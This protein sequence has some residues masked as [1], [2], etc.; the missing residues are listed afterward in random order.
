MNL[1]KIYEY[2]SRDDVQQ[3]MLKSAE[4]REVVGVFRN[5]GFGTRPNTIRYPKDIV[6]MARSGVV[7][8]HYSIERWSNPMALKTDNYSKMRSGWD[9]LLDLDCKDFEHGKIGALVFVQVLKKHGIIPSIKFSG[10]K[11]FHLG[12]PWEAIPDKIDYKPTVEMYPDLPR[13]IVS[14]LKDFT[15]DIL[16]DAILKS[17]SIE[18]LVEKTG[19]SK[20]E[21]LD[22][23]E[24]KPYEIVDVDPVMISPRHLVRMPYSLHKTSGFFSLPLSVH[25]LPGF[26]RETADPAKIKVKENFLIH[27]KE[28]EAQ[29]LVAEAIDWSSKYEKQKTK[30]LVQRAQITKKIPLDFAPP[31]IH[32]ILNGLSDGKKRSVFTLINFF[33]SLKWSWEE[34]EAKIFE[35]NTKNNPPINE[36][37]IRMQVRWH[38]NRNK[39]LLPPNCEYKGWYTDF[40]VCKPDSQC[41][42]HKK[43][44]KNPV[45]YSIKKATPIK[46]RRKYASNVRN[47]NENRK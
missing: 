23:E 47:N 36:N 8:F 10:N 45:N 4:G 41:G 25:D 12:I 33:S 21:I 16:R 40:G 24:L 9:L 42:G 44:I 15:K 14:Y 37:Y 39:I 29:V 26:K 32:N 3:A 13:S 17:F 1:G 19:K 2:Y 38:K 31:C 28:N 46:K 11:G 22:G 18:E 5:G 30:E 35:W 34:I 6:S 27:K 20:E 43:T 7:E